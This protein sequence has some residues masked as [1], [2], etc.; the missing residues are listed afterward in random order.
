MLYCGNEFRIE[1]CS[2]HLKFD[3]MVPRTGRIISGSF[4]GAVKYTYFRS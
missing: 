2:F 1:V 3:D 4:F